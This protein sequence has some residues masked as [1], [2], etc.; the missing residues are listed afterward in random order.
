MRHL[1][2]RMRTTTTSSHPLS[3]ERPFMTQGYSRPR[4]RR[5]RVG[6]CLDTCN[7]P[8]RD[9]SD[10]QGSGP[11]CGPYRIYKRR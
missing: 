9:C 8:T 4:H 6:P 1:G 5:L 10:L 7:Y 3:I 11:M 2:L